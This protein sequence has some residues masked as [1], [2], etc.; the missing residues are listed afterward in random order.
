MTEL[1]W[2]VLGKLVLE[3]RAES[4]IVAIVGR[5]EANLVRV[6]GFEPSPGDGAVQV[7]DKGRRYANAFIVLATL[8]TPRHPT[9]PIQTDR[10]VARCYGRTPAEAMALYVAASNALHNLGP[11]LHANGLGIY[12]SLDDTGGTQE[13]DPDTQQPLVS[14]VISLVATTQAVA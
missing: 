4:P 12:I 3:L 11:R 14:F 8:A 6:R 5:D 1:N 7:T 10:V 13:K 9:V 2:D